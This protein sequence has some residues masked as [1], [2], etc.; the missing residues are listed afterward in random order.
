MHDCVL[1]QCHN[2]QISAFCSQDAAE[3]TQMFHFRAPHVDLEAS[4]CRLRGSHLGR[5]GLP[6]PGRGEGALFGHL[7]KINRKPCNIWHIMHIDTEKNA[8]RAI[9]IWKNYS[10]SL[11]FE[12]RLSILSAQEGGPFP[13]IRELNAVGGV[14]ETDPIRGRLQ[15]Q[16]VLCLY[17]SCRSLSNTQN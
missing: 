11:I 15:D 3:S 16:D 7:K 5:W 9:H 8:F 6:H 10:D 12:L 14:K 4:K 1:F 17:V 2:E 13:S